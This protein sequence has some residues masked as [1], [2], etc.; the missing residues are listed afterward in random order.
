VLKELG[1]P[2]VPVIAPMISMETDETYR[3]F[4]A[5]FI[6]EAFRGILAI[7]LMIQLVTET[8]PSEATEGATDSAFDEGLE[9]ICRGIAGGRFWKGLD[10]AVERFDGIE[11]TNGGGRPVVGLFG[12]DYTRDNE[13]AN[14]RLLREVE[15]MGGELRNVSIWSSYLR[16]QLGIKPRNMMKKGRYMELPVDAGK[17]VVGAMDGRR[18]ASRFRSRLRCFRDPWYAEMMETASR[19]VD[20]RTDPVIIIAVARILDLIHH[21]ADGILNV[22][23]FQCALYTVMSAVLKKLCVDHDSLPNLTLFFD[24]QEKIHHRNR[25]EAFMHQVK[26]RH[27]SR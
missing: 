13:F 16:F 18:V 11:L 4:G 7:E 22:V 15:A 23:G 8:R 9:E 12:D 1:Y 10:A 2:D 24:F 3:S 21:G 26:Q 14:S 25:L 19:H 20:E 17:W 5:K 6:R 27:A